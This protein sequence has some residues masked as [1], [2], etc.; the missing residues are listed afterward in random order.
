MLEIVI[1]DRILGW[2][3]AVLMEM[4]SSRILSLSQKRG[5]SPDSNQV[6]G[7]YHAEGIIEGGM[8]RMASISGA[9]KTQS[10]LASSTKHY[11]QIRLKA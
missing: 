1:I 7:W 11:K 9:Y 2:Q 8:A 10:V 4:V 5:P 6:A 3:K